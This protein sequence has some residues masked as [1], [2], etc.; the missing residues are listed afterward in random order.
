MKK[1]MTKEQSIRNALSIRWEGHKKSYTNC[2]ICGTYFRYYP[3]RAGK[4]LYCSKKCW[5]STLKGKIFAPASKGER[6]NPA[7]EFK[8][9]TNSYAAVHEWIKRRKGQPMTCNH[10]GILHIESRRIQWSNKSGEYKRVLSDWERL[11]IPCHRKHES[12]LRKSATA[13]QLKL[14]RAESYKKGWDDC[15]EKYAKK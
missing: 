6:R 8:G 3:Y 14:I 2:L 5:Y 7:N 12:T 4:S 10:C 11:C 9:D 13:K 1:K 15:L